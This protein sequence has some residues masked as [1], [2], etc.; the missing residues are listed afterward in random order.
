MLL[1]FLLDLFIWD[2]KLILKL[3]QFLV[4]NI[5]YF[6]C[7]TQILYHIHPASVTLIERWCM[8]YWSAELTGFQES[9]QMVGIMRSQ[10]MGVFLCIVSV[11]EIY[12]ERI[13]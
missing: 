13:E 8:A 6:W 3:E 7:K 11:M 9:L 10:S 12:T 5:Y 2:C 1:I 4:Y